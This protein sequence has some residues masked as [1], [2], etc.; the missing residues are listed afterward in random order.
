MIWLEELKKQLRLKRKKLLFGIESAKKVRDQSPSAM[1]SHSDTSRSEKEKLIFALENDLKKLDEIIS[2]VPN[3]LNNSNDNSIVSEWR[4]IE[5]SLA[6]KLLRICIVPEGIGGEV[7][8]DIRLLSSKTPLG[9]VI[10]GKKKGD[11]FI[12]NQQEGKIENII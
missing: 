7:I 3:K 11:L 5:I 2:S 12:F 1:E 10:L 9:E 6:G 4:Y 8:N